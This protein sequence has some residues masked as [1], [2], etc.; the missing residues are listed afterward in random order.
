MIAI[1]SDT[2]ASPPTTCW[3]SH[4]GFQASR[5]STAKSPFCLAA[6]FRRYWAGPSSRT[7]G[8]QTIRPVTAA[9]TTH[10]L[11][12]RTPPVARYQARN[13]TISGSACGLVMSAIPTQI[14]D[15]V[16]CP[17]TAS[18][19]A[20]TTGRMYSD[21]SWPQPLL[22]PKIAGWRKTASADRVAMPRLVAQARPHGD[23][24]ADIGQRGRRL[25]HGPKPW[26]LHDAAEYPGLGA[27]APAEN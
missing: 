24:Q 2:V 12:P 19:R 6:T 21:S 16:A 14:A 9:T 10:R 17:L 7:N 25:H 18:S 26:V 20:T 27:E 5:D 15:R 3:I 8:I 23:R 11:R 22:I 4:H 1:W 13:G